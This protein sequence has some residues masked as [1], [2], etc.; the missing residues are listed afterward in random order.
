MLCKGTSESVSK[1][2]ECKQGREARMRL[3]SGVN[4]G[5]KTCRTGVGGLGGCMEMVS[6]GDNEIGRWVQ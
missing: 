4:I 3:T 1:E 6:E 2:T 5:T